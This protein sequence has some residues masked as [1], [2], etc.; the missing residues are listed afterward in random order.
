[1][2]DVVL[3]VA[4][5]AKTNGFDESVFIGWVFDVFQVASKPR[6]INDPAIG[7][8]DVWDAVSHYPTLMRLGLG[9]TAVLLLPL[10][11]M[12]LLSAVVLENG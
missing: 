5:I 12:T 2:H 10:R 4:L 3:G 9:L 1:M 6:S 7:N 11:P 8:A